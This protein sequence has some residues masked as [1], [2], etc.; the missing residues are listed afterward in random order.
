[1]MSPSFQVDDNVALTSFEISSG[2]Q[3]R[4]GDLEDVV[5]EGWKGCA[6]LEEDAG[7]K[8]FIWALSLS[9]SMTKRL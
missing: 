8:V 6:V 7:S 4:A 1:M 3:A 2:S 5:A 9:L